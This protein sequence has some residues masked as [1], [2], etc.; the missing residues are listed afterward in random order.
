M[1]Q[2]VFNK[3]INEGGELFVIGEIPA[4]AWHTLYHAIRSL[5]VIPQGHTQH[6][7]YF[8]ALNPMF[9]GQPPCSMGKGLFINIPTPMSTGSLALQSQTC[10]IMQIWLMEG[11]HKSEMNKLYLM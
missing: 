1:P 8:I 6:C 7:T 11:V 4:D 3:Y 2:L 5:G 9:R 10:I